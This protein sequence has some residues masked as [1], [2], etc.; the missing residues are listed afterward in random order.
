VE[1]RPP[2]AGLLPN[3]PERPPIPGAAHP[4]THTRHDRA[5]SHQPER[6]RHPRPGLSPTQP[7]TSRPATIECFSSTRTGPAATKPRAQSA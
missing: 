6:P 2:T 3:P 5:L 4:Q 1:S 7:P